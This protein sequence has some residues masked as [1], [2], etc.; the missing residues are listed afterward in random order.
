MAAVC[1]LELLPEA[2]KC[3]DDRKLA[4]GVMCG[5][6]IMGSTLLIGV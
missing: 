3:N 5:A 2:K 6:V 4:L 1:V